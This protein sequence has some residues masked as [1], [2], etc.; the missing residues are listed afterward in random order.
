MTFADRSVGLIWFLDSSEASSGISVAEICQHFENAGFS[1]QNRSRLLNNMRKDKRLIRGRD[2][3]FRLNPRY[4]VEVEKEFSKYLGAG[5][6]IAQNQIL[7]TLCN[8]S[9]VLGNGYRQVLMD[10]A[11]EQR[12][13]WAGT[14]HELRQVLSSL[15]H[16]LA[17]NEAVIAAPWY[18]QVSG[19]SG[20]SQAQRVKFILKQKVGVTFFL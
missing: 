17:P 4:E 3:T 7:D 18:K 5:P 10:L 2:D 14:A 12:V 6:N 19:T 9:S 16:I 20:P 11:D 15:L 8:L 13:S 1:T